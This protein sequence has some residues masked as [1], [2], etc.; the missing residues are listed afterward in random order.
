MW[1]TEGLARTQAPKYLWTR[2]KNEKWVPTLGQARRGGGL[3]LNAPISAQRALNKWF[4]GWTDKQSDFPKLVS[5]PWS[6]RSSE[7]PYCEMAG[8]SPVFW[9]YILF[10]ILIPITHSLLETAPK[11]GQAFYRQQCSAVRS[12]Q[13]KASNKHI[14]NCPDRS[15]EWLHTVFL[16]SIL[17]W[18]LASSSTTWTSSS[19]IKPKNAS[20]HML[21]TIHLPYKQ[22][23]NFK[24]TSSFTS[25]P[26]SNVKHSKC[27]DVFQLVRERL[28]PVVTTDAL[29]RGREGS[30]RGRLKIMHFRSRHGISM[31]NYRIILSSSVFPL[32]T[33]ICLCYR[34]KQV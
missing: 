2:K 29:P 16:L 9:F 25:K 5:R 20:N 8:L 15:G 17:C 19:Q 33:V 27:L 21:A 1:N 31:K 14:R 23:Q 26:E 13:R 22:Q 24:L 11:G 34:L 32:M 12:S 4:I 3:K 30:T 10:N 28:R 7:C 6:T 18:G